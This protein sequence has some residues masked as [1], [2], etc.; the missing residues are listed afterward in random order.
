MPAIDLNGVGDALLNFGENQRERM[1]RASLMQNQLNHQQLNN[2]ATQWER[3][4]SKWDNNPDVQEPL[5]DVIAK[6]GT[7]EPTRE[8][9]AALN[10][11]WVKAKQEANKIWAVHPDNPINKARQ[12]TPAVQ[13]AAR[14][15]NGLPSLPQ[16]P[17]QA[18]P[19]Q[20]NL[21]GLPWRAP[22]TTPPFV[23]DWPQAGSAAQPST[24]PVQPNSQPMGGGSSPNATFRQPTQGDTSGSG[25]TRANQSVPVDQAPTFSAGAAAIPP[26]INLSD[27]LARPLYGY[28]HTGIMPPV[29]EDAIKTML[30]GEASMNLAQRKLA[31]MNPYIDQMGSDP[32]TLLPNLMRMEVLGGGSQGLAIGPL[33]SAM[34]QQTVPGQ[35]TVGLFEAAHP[36]FLKL[37]GY[38][39]DSLDPDTPVRYQ[40]NK[41]SHEPVAAQISATKKNLTPTAQG[42]YKYNPNTGKLEPVQGAEGVTPVALAP[43]TSSSTVH[44]PGQEDQTTT[45]VKRRG[46]PT[47]TTPP[48]PPPVNI[49]S[50]GTVKSTGG[51]QSIANNYKAWMAGD[52]SLNEK[53][54]QAARD[55]AQKNGLPIPTTYSASAQKDLAAIDPILQEVRRVRDM[56]KSRPNLDKGELAK[57]Y[58][59]Y[60]YLHQGTPND[61]I[62]SGLSFADL[63]SAA[64]ALKG[65]GSR[66]EAILNRALEHTPRV[67]L[68]FSDRSQILNLLGEMETRLVEGRQSI[69]ANEK[70]SGVIGN[71]PAPPAGATVAPR[72]ADEYLRGVNAR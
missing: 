47:V 4:A 31:L 52:A 7:I 66:A 69:L 12:G 3:V 41:L 1:L 25:D 9:I 19:A 5:L 40:V 45:S 16:P 35:T 14:Q 60:T 36:G 53:Q 42:F 72:T 18:A 64:Q 55:Y 24:S 22:L 65:T 39:V 38:D 37:Q 67:G 50:S 51:D 49:T 48:T 59:R 17:A 8:N 20:S 58:V 57:D 62:I 21:L 27:L 33:L 70:K 23:G 11:A 26:P 29:L 32:A 6:A 2:L 46:S 43:T 54:Q 71:L 44:V 10:D 63:R 56:I 61:D 15:A 13:Q 34:T 30:P 28:E 68:N